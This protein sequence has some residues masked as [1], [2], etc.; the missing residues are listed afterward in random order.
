MNTDASAAA[1]PRE[2]IS[3]E[4]I[5]AWLHR[6]VIHLAL[7]GYIAV[8]LQVSLVPLHFDWAHFDALRA[9]A[10]RNFL[11]PYFSLPDILAN[12]ALYAPVGALGVLAG[13]RVGHSTLLAS[14]MA[15]LSGLCISLFCEGVQSL[16][17]ARVSSI[18]DVVCNVLGTTGGAAFVLV[19]GPIIARVAAGWRAQLRRQPGLAA[20]KLAGAALLLVTLRPYGL[21]LEP[22]SAYRAVRGAHVSPIY[23]WRKLSRAPLSADPRVTA[24]A[25]R[26]RWDYALDRVADGMLY[27]LFAALCASA[28]RRYY[29]YRPA[30]AARFAVGAAAFV[31]AGVTLL[32]IFL[33][34][35]GLDTAHFVVALM[36]AAPAALLA[37]T[38]RPPAIGPDGPP[39][40]RGTLIFPGRSGA[41]TFAVASIF[42]L[43][44]GLAPFTF[45][46][47]ECH[48]VGLLGHMSW[49]P[50][51]LLGRSRPNTAFLAITDKLLMFFLWGLAAAAIRPRQTAW[52][53]EALTIVGAAGALATLLELL[54]AFVP[55]RWM[56]ST[57]LLLALL[58]AAT[59]VVVERAAREY[60]SANLVRVTDDLLTRQLTEGRS[61]RPIDTSQPVARKAAV[62]TSGAG[63]SAA[64]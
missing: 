38:R 13:R 3:T 41:V 15:L 50:F 45:T 44:R 59:G 2:P 48:R 19:A 31:A 20:A 60:L 54:H 29:G 9:A 63:P 32:R 11:Y 62:P 16:E 51:S 61:I 7:A 22:K 33:P 42:L 27:G 47:S 36:G 35:R 64:G 21:V 6:R 14:L 58:G 10:W 53:R 25:Q 26:A 56:D 37:A 28:V 8:L 24:S 40:R 34:T 49:L 23:T 39:V 5:V 4:P 1:A 17:P 12:I 18:V 30:R 55:G 52:R 43:V 46:L 57:N